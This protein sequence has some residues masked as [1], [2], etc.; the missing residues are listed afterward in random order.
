MESDGCPILPLITP[1]DNYKTKAVQ[2]M[3]REYCNAHAR[4]SNL[5]HMDTMPNVIAKA[6]SREDRSRFPGA[7]L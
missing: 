6:S 5:V 7:H 1:L 3:L 2:S 4:E